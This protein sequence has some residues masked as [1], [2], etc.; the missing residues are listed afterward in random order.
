MMDIKR[1]NDIKRFYDLLERLADTQS[2]TRTLAT[3]SGNLPWAD[4]G[5]YFFLENGE[6]RSHSGNGSRVVR[7]GTH[8][9][10][11]GAKST[12]WGR[13]NN[14]RGSSRS[15]GGNH[16]SS[17]FRLIVGTALIERDELLC[18]TWDQTNAPRETRSYES[19]LEILVSGIIGDM[20][21]LCLPVEDH[22]GPYSARGIVERGSIALLS[23][24]KREQIDPPSESWL[25]HHCKRPL[26]RASGLWNQE[27]VQ[28][29]YDPT[30]LDHFERLLEQVEHAQ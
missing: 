12:L 21:F 11:E 25:G 1:L 3:S 8:A 13:L 27:H 2:G 19:E 5:V 24:Y 30:F 20:P 7:I 23:N 9:L 15:G 26:V 29:D 17:I 16:R 6:M 10:K 14:H 4:R 22:P 28:E 18:P